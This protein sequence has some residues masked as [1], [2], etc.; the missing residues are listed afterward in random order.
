MD[1]VRNDEV[2]RRTCIEREFT[3]RVDQ[4][5]L[6]RFGNVERMD[7]YRMASRVMMVEVNGGRVWGR[8]VCWIYGVMGALGTR[9]MT[10]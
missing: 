7:E 2:R 10:V 8:P 4:R 1:R 6:R 9:G 5:V 3:S